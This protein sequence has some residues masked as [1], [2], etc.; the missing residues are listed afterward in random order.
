VEFSEC[1]RLIADYT[2]IFG[3]YCLPSVGAFGL[4]AQLI[5]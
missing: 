4:A 5:L 2:A 1:F 3:D